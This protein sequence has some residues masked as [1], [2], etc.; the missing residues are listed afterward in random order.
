MEEIALKVK[1][2]LDEARIL[3]LSTQVVL[4]TEWSAVFQARFDDL[5]EACRGLTVCAL[6][7]T[8]FALLLLIWPGAYH[9]IVL[10]GSDSP[11]FQRFI[12]R[13]MSSA[14]LP[15]AIGLGLVC[16]VSTNLI[17]GSG[18]GVAASVAIS[19]AALALWYRPQ[20]V[21]LAFDLS[22]KEASMAPADR[23][24]KDPSSKEDIKNKVEHVLTEARVVLPGAQAL[25]GFQFAAMLTKTFDAL[26]ETSRIVHLL[27]LFALAFASILL[28]TPASYHRVV[29]KG[30][31][32]ERLHRIASGLMLAALIPLAFGFAGDVFVVV[33]MVTA[34]LAI[35]VAGA[36]VILAVAFGLWFV[37]SLYCKHHPPKEESLDRRS[38]IADERRSV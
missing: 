34:S 17:W 24:P 36:G 31:F 16:Y 13:V 33:R 9:R 28:I 3:V 38:V 5:S 7:V 6:G 2:A 27:S 8:L 10:H 1:T 32:T 29:E 12:F 4:A 23:A 35:G 37:L 19:G 20:I 14:H 11:R 15:L 21:E 25:L 18:S 26:P 22:K 30:E